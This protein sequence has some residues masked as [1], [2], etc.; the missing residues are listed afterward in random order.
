MTLVVTFCKCALNLSSDV[1]RDKED[2]TWGLL[3][4]STPGSVDP[5]G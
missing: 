4:C 5:R 2:N 1:G 3:Q